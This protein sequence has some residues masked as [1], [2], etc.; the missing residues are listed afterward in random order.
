VVAAAGVLAAF[1]AALTLT[2]VAA[3][4]LVGL[5]AL[6]FLILPDRLAPWFTVALCAAPTAVFLTRTQD[7]SE[8]LRSSIPIGI[9]STIFALIISYVIRGISVR[10]HERARLI[11]ELE[12]TRA[13]L[14]RVSREAGIAEER[15]R[16]AGEIHDTVAQGLS[17]V[18]MLVQAAEASLDTDPESARPHLALAERTARENLAETRAIVAALTPA[19]LAEASLPEAVRRLAV[20]HATGG[21]T[22]SVTVTGE[23]RR[24]STAVEV[25]LLRAA[26]E[27]LANALRHAKADSVR[28][29]LTYDP[30]TILLEVRDD[31]RGFEPTEN[32]PGYGLQ[33]MRSRTVQVGGSL[34]IHS[35]PDA[36]T[37]LRIEVPT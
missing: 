20:G 3:N 27:G 33:T 11:E 31:G 8:A 35:G 16:L 37:R 22:V 26:Q 9:A 10:S 36:G 12:S 34:T 25:V 1:T 18:V 6:M 4:L 15:Q 7:L 2:P 30:A 5:P 28:L 32:L 13:E 21:T 29:L 24:A 23:P 19:P 17:S 14:A